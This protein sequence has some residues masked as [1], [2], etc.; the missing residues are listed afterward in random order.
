MVEV[1][2]KVDGSQFSAGVMAGEL[3]MRS[4]GTDLLSSA[5]VALF[6][7]AMHTFE[8]LFA[9]GRLED[10]VVYRG[11]AI[12]KPKHNAIRYGR[13]PVGGV[14]LFDVDVG[15][16]RR[17]SH[18]EASARAAALGLEF[19]PLLYRG[20]VSGPGDL[21]ALL[22][23][24]SVLGEAKIEGVVAK[25]YARFGR[26]GK[27][28]MVKHVAEEF[29]EHARRDWKERNPGSTDFVRQLGLSLA[30]E[31]RWSKVVQHLREAGRL[32]GEPRD[33]GAL[34]KVLH[35]EIDEEDAAPLKEELW[36]HFAPEIKRRAGA[37]LAEFYKRRLL[38]Q[39]F[40][41]TVE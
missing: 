29:K 30:T 40:A 23:R 39:A 20:V 7:P 25:N 33:I 22:D 26:D 28:L 32:S 37:G 13:V 16:E 38:Q 10:G 24:V 27:Q 12:C 5:P 9:E 17:L 11:E 35:E 19:V 2:E 15:P 34:F 36:R 8:R 3:R 4:K 41:E 1:T 6:A 18:A 14:I 31:A 21:L